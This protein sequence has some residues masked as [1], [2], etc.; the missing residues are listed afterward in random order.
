MVSR[1]KTPNRPKVTEKEISSV[2]DNVYRWEDNPSLSSF[3]TSHL[4]N[5]APS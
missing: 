2:L 3:A 5:Y 1:P 4:G